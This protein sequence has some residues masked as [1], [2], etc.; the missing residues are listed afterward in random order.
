MTVFMRPKVSVCIPTYNG[1][2]YL[3]ECL[4]SVMRQTFAA[5]EILIVDDGSSDSS[6]SIAQ[7]YTRADKRIRLF[8]NKKHLGLVSNWNHRVDLA[9]REWIKFVFQDDILAP[10]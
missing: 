1:A 6:A 2:A 3:S 4:E 9:S 8:V 7:Q 5:I 10:P